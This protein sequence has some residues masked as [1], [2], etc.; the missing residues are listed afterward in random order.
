MDTMCCTISN[1][2]LTLIDCVVKYFNKSMDVSYII[3]IRVIITPSFKT[4]V[5]KFE[6]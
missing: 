6:K 4:L 1:E 3:I 5:A 2:K